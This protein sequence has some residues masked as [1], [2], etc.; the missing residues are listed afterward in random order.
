MFAQCRCAVLYDIAHDEDYYPYATLITNDTTQLIR[1]LRRW[2]DDSNPDKEPFR[3]IYQVK[4]SDLMP[5]GKELIYL[6]ATPVAEE[7]YNIGNCTLFLDEAHE[8]CSQWSI[9]W[10][11]RKVVRL[12]RHQQL[13]IIWISQ[14]MNEIHRE[15]RRNTDEYHFYKIHEPRDLEAIK[16]RCGEECAIKVA[17][18][19]RLKRENGKLIP[20]TCLVWVSDEQ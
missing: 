9:D 18:L 3:A 4:E 1:E 16:E 14:S 12:A 7:C 2:T 11:L 6:T 15:I 10:R 13:N 20:G 8:L 19:Q 5:K 17:G